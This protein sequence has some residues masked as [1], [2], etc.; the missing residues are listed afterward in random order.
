MTWKNPKEEK[1][2]AQGGWQWELEL[3]EQNKNAKKIVSVVHEPI[4]ISDGILFS[5]PE[6]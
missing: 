6:D 4:P 3:E 5:V 1:L 2:P